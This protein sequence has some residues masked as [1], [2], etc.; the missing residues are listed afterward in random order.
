MGAAAIPNSESWKSSAVLDEVY[1]RSG[2]YRPRGP[3]GWILW[4]LFGI[5][6]HTG[7]WYCP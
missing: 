1:G 6:W 2:T 4:K 7:L 5:E 3:F